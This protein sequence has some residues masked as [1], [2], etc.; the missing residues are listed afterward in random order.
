MIIRWLEDYL[1][2]DFPRDPLI[3]DDIFDAG[4][5]MVVYGGSEVGKSYFVLQLALALAS[6]V[7]FLGY[8]VMRPCRVVLLQAEMSDFRCQERASRLSQGFPVG[9]K[10]LAIMST[11][12]MKIDRPEGAEMLRHIVKE[13]APEVVITDPLRAFFAGDENDSASVERFFANVAACQ[14]DPQ[15]SLIYPHHVRKG[16]VGAAAEDAEKA[17]ARGSGLITD[18]PSTAIGL[19]VNEAQTVWAAHFTKTRNREKHPPS[20]KLTVD[21][22]TGLFVTSQDLSPRSYYVYLVREA[23][24]DG[25]RMQ[26]EV[27]REIAEATKQQMR[28]VYDWIIAAEHDGI[29]SRKE[30]AGAGKP[31]LLK[32]T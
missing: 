21:R 4:E 9:P 5:K 10:Q 28:T 14:G 31:Y 3:A 6:G 27:I 30:V 12:A 29:L 19:T 1:Q 22:D 13:L 17:S 11:E 26:A 16:L 23:L 20:L 15:F 25:E 24:K 2:A 7:E 32:L 18:R 8:E